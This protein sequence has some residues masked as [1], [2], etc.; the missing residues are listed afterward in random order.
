MKNKTLYEGVL[1]VYL[2]AFDTNSLPL[3]ALQKSKPCFTS[4]HTLRIT[5]LSTFLIT[6]MMLVNSPLSKIPNNIN[7]TITV[8]QDVAPHRHV[9]IQKSTSDYAVFPCQYTG[10]AVPLCRPHFLQ[11]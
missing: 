7:G 1:Q 6:S 9:P 2:R 3:V 10:R 5:S 4:S 11:L 8:K